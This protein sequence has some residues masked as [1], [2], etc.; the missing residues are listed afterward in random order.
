MEYAEEQSA[1]ARHGNFAE[2]D[3]TAVMNATAFR[4]FFSGIYSKKEEAVIRELMC[5][6]LDAHVSADQTERKIQLYLPNE[7]A[8]F[9]KIRDYGTGLS[10]SGMRNVFGAFFNSSKRGDNDQIGCFGLGSKS[11]FS[12]TDMYIA[13]SYYNGMKSVYSCFLEDGKP[14]IA[15]MHEEATEEPAGLEVNFPVT[16]WD[17][18]SNFRNAAIRVLR[19]FKPEHYEVHG[20]RITVQDL[21]P[22]QHGEGWFLYQ[23]NR[24]GSGNTHTHGLIVRMG[25]VDYPLEAEQIRQKLPTHCHFIADLNMVVTMPVGWV[26]P[27]PSRES[28]EMSDVTI[29]NLIKKFTEIGESMVAH[30]QTSIDA[31]PNRRAAVKHVWDIAMKEGAP[32]YQLRKHIKMMWRGQPLQLAIRPT[33]YGLRLTKAT[34]TFSYRKGVRTPSVRED[35]INVLAL[36]DDTSTKNMIFVR[37]AKERRLVL[38]SVRFTEEDALIL[39]VISKKYEVSNHTL[40][41]EWNNNTETFKFQTACKA[42]GLSVEKIS[43]ANY[44]TKYDFSFTKEKWDFFRRDSGIGWKALKSPHDL[45]QP[46]PTERVQTTAGRGKL[47]SQKGDVYVLVK[48]VSSAAECWSAEPGYDLSAGGVYADLNWYRPKMRKGWAA[49]PV[50]LKTGEDC[51]FMKPGDIKSAVSNINRALGTKVKV[52]GVSKDTVLKKMA[53]LGN[54]IHVEDFILQSIQKL[55]N[56]EDLMKA[57]CYWHSEESEVRHKNEWNDQTNR[58]DQIP[59]YNIQRDDRALEHLRIMKALFCTNEFT[60]LDI[61]PW[62]HQGEITEFVKQ[63]ELFQAFE[64]RAYNFVQFRMFLAEHYFHIAP[65]KWPLAVVQEAY[66]MLVRAQSNHFDDEDARRHAEYIK[67]VDNHRNCKC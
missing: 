65:M 49:D 48:D 52:I 63:H 9:F 27:T 14:K 12:V 38:S 22:I 31:Q 60:A 67:L 7:N 24:W 11:P 17:A 32:L 30:T 10:D 34:A 21:Q 3:M 59:Y 42:V 35:E 15:L 23:Y 66:P 2:T 39:E 45:E 13:T 5:N 53:K 40:Q 64:D 44:D 8:P 16:E 29:A 61:L 47:A 33:M 51:Y 18:W 56:N 43:V 37:N 6:A 1:V 25:C 41:N 4:V 50:R 36:Y 55:L 54:W 26:Q 57:V 19:P 20:Q 58:Y 28:L 62:N 46:E